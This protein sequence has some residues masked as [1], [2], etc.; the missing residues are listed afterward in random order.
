MGQSSRTCAWVTTVGRYRVVRVYRRPTP[1][2]SDPILG[3]HLY[4][5]TSKS[6][7]FIWS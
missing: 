7:K 3:D 5:R 1:F 4:V 6:W 2:Y